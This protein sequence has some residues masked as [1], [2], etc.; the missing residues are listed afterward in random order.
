MTK[1][2][3]F[4]RVVGA[5][6]FSRLARARGLRCYVNRGTRSAA[7]TPGVNPGAEQGG[8]GYHTEI[9]RE[10]KFQNSRKVK[11]GVFAGKEVSEITGVV[12]KEVGNIEGEG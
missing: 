2:V 1:T 8:G 4:S 3:E 6:H 12:S 9:G 10:T 7:G 5:E 11:K